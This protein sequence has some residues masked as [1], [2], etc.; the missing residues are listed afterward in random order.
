MGEGCTGGSASSKMDLL[1]NSR[2]V[3]STMLATRNV[4]GRAGGCIGALAY[5]TSSLHT[6]SAGVHI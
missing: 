4:R 5:A 2:W 1:T 3:G 6:Q